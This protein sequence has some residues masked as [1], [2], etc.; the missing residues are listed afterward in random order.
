MKN[1][2]ILQPNSDQSQAIAKYLKKK[3]NDFFITGGF[4]ED[5]RTFRSIPFFDKLIKISS[6]YKFENNN[7]DLIL[8]TGANSTNSFLKKEKQIKIGKILFNQK[9][10]FASDKISMLNVISELKIP[11]PKTYTDTKGIVEFP[12]FYKQKFETGGGLRG[13]LKNRSDYEL[14]SHDKTIFFQE[15]IDSPHTFGVGFLARD[16]IMITSFIQKEIYSFPKEGGSGVI[17]T[18]FYDKKLIDYT[19]KILKKLNYCGWGLAEFKYCSKRKDYVFME[20]N[21]KFWASL[22]FALLNNSDFFQELFDIHYNSKSVKCIVYFNRLAKYGFKNYLKLALSHK[23]C[24]KL[25][26][27]S[28]LKTLIIDAIPVTL[29]NYLKH[30]F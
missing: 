16:G 3:S 9:N 6:D 27:W 26:I 25:N 10:L 8:P 24:Y 30:V 2:L 4:T 13:I 23:H 29:I 17:L 28:S 15:Y 1:I 19:N 21:A 14:I 12:I 11:I 22:E 18:T 20:L 5:V 7:Y